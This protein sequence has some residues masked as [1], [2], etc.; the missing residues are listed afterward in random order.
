MKEIEDTNKW[1]DILISLI[2]RITIV[3]TFSKVVHRFSAISMKIPMVC[4]TKMKKKS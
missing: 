1:K 4:F 2:G 3:K